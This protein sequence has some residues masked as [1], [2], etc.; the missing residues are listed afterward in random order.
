[1][2]DRRRVLLLLAAIAFGALTLRL[3]HLW[4]WALWGSDSGEYLFL[5]TTLAENGALLQEGYL[6]WGHAYPWFQGMQLLAAAAALLCGLPTA[7]TLLWLI[8]AAGA[9]AVPALFLAGRRFVSSDAA[10][11]GSG[12]YA[13]A[14]P[15]VFAN[16]H[17]MP[18]SLADP[19]SLLLIYTFI[20]ILA[21][22][23]RWLPAFGVL[24]AG[25]VVVH[26]F[27]LLLA[28]AGCTGMLAIE[29]AAGNRRRAPYFTLAVA[30]AL[31]SLYW[32]GYATGFRVAILGDTGLPL[33]A[34]VV[35]PLVVLIVIRLLA[36]QIP[37]PLLDVPQRPA[38]IFLGAFLALLLVIGYGFI[39]GVPGTTIPVGLEAVPYLLP[40]LGW[41]ALAAAPG[42][43]L[44]QRG[45][46]LLCG[47]T[48]PI[49]GLAIV[50]GLTES[51]LLIAYRHAPYLL[52]PLAL[53]AGA[54]FVTLLQ[55]Q[56][57]VRRPRFIAGLV[58]ILLCGALTAYP[59]ADVMGGFQEGSTQV[60]LGCV[61]WTQQVEP[62][63]FIVSDHRLSSLAF[64]LGEHN[65]SWE[66]GAEVL[67]SVG[68]VREVAAPTAGV[69]QVDYVLLSNE[70]RR[71]VALLQ[72]EAAEPLS[73]E[74]NTKFGSQNYPVVLNAGEC[75]LYRQV[76][77]SL[78]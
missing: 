2:A 17:A 73:A 39:W 14:F 40:P 72:W 56:P 45:G 49:A 68:V 55:T 66:H 22:P 63:A 23:R 48:L 24:L 47:W 9:L 59:P 29:A 28:I 35:A 20:G 37:L 16:S 62:G 1:M 67:A 58:A 42:L 15:V 12:C 76:P 32:V 78:M 31:T 50:G 70:M 11:V 51:H 65:A 38:R 21:A 36:P 8:P 41:L 64:G 52:A 43:V 26:H 33:E 61:L 5:T 27:T 44:A 53:M 10:L 18:G 6:G 46:W 74:A 30:A 25:L 13:V 75:Q 54:G 77:D 71:G 19:L 57:S 4:H 3:S 7:A 69:Q 34:L 60:E